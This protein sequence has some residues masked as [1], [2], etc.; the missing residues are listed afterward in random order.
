MQPLPKRPGLIVAPG[1]FDG[2]SAR[3]VEEAGFEALYVSGGAV[4]RSHGVP[5][6][7]LLTMT[8]VVDAI[9]R[10]SDAVRLPIVADADTGYGNAINV[11]RAVREFER[12]GVAA[13]HIEDQV[14][15]KRCGHY[16]GK[17][18]ISAGEMIGKVHAAVDARDNSALQIIA[19]TDARAGLGLDEAI[20]RANA[21]VD[22]GADMAFVEAPE[23]VDEIE[24][25]AQSVRAPV[26]INMFQGGKTPLLPASEVGRL[27]YRLMIVPSD[28][29]RAAIAAMETVA[30]VLQRDGSSA[31]ALEQL[32]PF[33]ERDRLVKLG[34]YDAR[35]QRYADFAGAA[36]GAARRIS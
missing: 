14:T 18:V 3:I 27:G 9:R 8:E 35:G 19:R 36:D 26:V 22:A 24:R 12:A 30:E 6:I 29:Q 7:G 20:D 1:V 31:S 16:E 17:E 21:Y 15:P 2:L 11:G 32:A 4:A 5:D 23:S 28:L 33:P 13:L 34:E 10:V 25:I